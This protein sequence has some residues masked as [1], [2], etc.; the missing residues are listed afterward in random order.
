VIR[1]RRLVTSLLLAACGGTE[2]QT[3]LEIAIQSGDGQTAVSGERVAERYAVI[4]TKG[5]QPEPGVAVTWTV[6]SGGGVVTPPASSTDGAGVA[7]A[8]HTLG[9][10]AGAQQV[11]AS[12]GGAPQ[13]SVRFT[14]TARAVPEPVVV[15][16]IP[17]P[18][19]YGIHDTFVR[20]GL[21]FVCAWNTGVMIFDVGNGISGGSPAS[22]VLVS[23]VV[24][25]AAPLG[26]LSAHNAWWFHNPVTGE[27]RYLFVGQEGPGTIGVSSSGDIK[28]I[29]VSDLARPRE[30]GSFHYEGGGTHNFW[31]DE[32]RQ[33]LYAAYYNVGVV[34]V[35]ISGT[36]S[37]D[38]SGRLIARSAPGG[39][40]S[41]YMWGIMLAG[42]RLYAND[43]L[44]G[45]W[46]LSP[47]TLQPVAGGNNVPERFGSDLWVR[48]DYAYSGTWGAVP[49]NGAVGNA[50]K[51]WRLS[52]AGAPVLA[53]SL[54]VTGIETVSDVEVS[55]DGNLLVLSA[56]R[57]I[58]AGL[59]VYRL[60]DPVKPALAGRIMVEAGLHTATLARI[61]GKLYAF[62]ARNPRDPALIIYDLSGLR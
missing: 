11:R 31:V 20:D 18:P 58:M 53:D 43:M 38:I 28:V 47:T 23:S 61:G 40:G 2:P 60:T 6:I 22:P 27:K 8:V 54:I 25:S 26:T 15:A 39:N 57:G 59:H 51:I 30:V 52:A 32:A 49:R 46:Q 41:T 13:S 45:F 55:D 44:S 14:A 3:P 42:G 19:N 10:L 56:E 21:A 12:I 16:S 24:P 17:I 9:V 5:G 48:G 50:L 7:R 37:G 33:V 1:A 4:V 62:A 29:D 36:L 35:D 34:A